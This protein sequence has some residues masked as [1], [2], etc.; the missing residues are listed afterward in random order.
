M[1][2]TPNRA[3]I[4]LPDAEAVTCYTSARVLSPYHSLSQYPDS[5]RARVLRWAL[6]A[7]AAGLDVLMFVWPD[8]CFC[9]ALVPRCAAD[10]PAMLAPP[11]ILAAYRHAL[12]DPHARK[13]F[14]PLGE[15]IE[16]GLH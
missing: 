5:I 8:G 10:T 12:S 3:A 4:P 16:R 7:D 13:L 15:H 14:H 6:E 11:A 2:H 1:Y 9:F